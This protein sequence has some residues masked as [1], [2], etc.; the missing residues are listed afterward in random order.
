MSITADDRAW[1]DQ[2]RRHIDACKTSVTS[3]G[4]L[5]NA[6]LTDIASRLES[7][8]KECRTML[9]GPQE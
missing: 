8:F 7:I 2:V 9:E 6:K 4:R 5:D 3:N 1:L